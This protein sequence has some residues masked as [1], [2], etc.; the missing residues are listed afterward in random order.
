MFSERAAALVDKIFEFRLA[1]VHLER[2]ADIVMTDIETQGGQSAMP[3]RQAAPLALGVS[4]LHFCYAPNAPHVLRD[5]TF[6]IAAGEHVALTGPS[7]AGKTT[8][9]KLLMGLLQPSSGTVRINGMPLARYGLQNFRRHLA[10]V[11]Q[12]D[13]LFSGSLLDNVTLFDPCPDLDHCKECLR[14]ADMDAVVAGLPMQLYT[15]VGDMGAAL[16]GG[17]KQRLLLA[18]ALYRRPAIL[19]L[20]EFTSHL[21]IVSEQTVSRRLRALPL[22]RVVVAHRNETIEQAD[23]EIRVAATMP[24]RGIMVDA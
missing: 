21:D 14:I 23:R 18:R 7:G 24:T 12:D 9:V 2:V 13:H 17:Q 22:T 16:S 8:L 1:K 3:Q 15:L 11:M 20:D 6:D 10:A 5:L 4:N 19:F